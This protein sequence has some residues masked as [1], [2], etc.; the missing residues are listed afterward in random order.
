[1]DGTMLACLDDHGRG[2]CRGTVEMRMTSDRAF[3]DMKSF[4]RCEFHF[5]KRE[6]SAQ[7]TLS[8]GYL[9]DTVPSWF[10]ETYAGERWDDD[11]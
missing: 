8:D 11:Y 7:K 1:M 5:A 4:P 3:T 9:G 6:K 10:D 2:E